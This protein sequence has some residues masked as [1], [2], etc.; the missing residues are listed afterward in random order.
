MSMFNVQFLIENPELAKML[1]MKAIEYGD[2]IAPPGRRKGG[3]T[4]AKI[5][6]EELLVTDRV[7]EIVQD[8]LNR[9]VPKDGSAAATRRRTKAA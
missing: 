5:L 9:T 6:V 2:A 7:D 8:Y 3:S 4:L 1:Q